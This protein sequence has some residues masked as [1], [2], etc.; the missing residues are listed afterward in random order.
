MPL[1]QLA[2]GARKSA[3]PRRKRELIKE[4]GQRRGAANAS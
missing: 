3:K 2:L 4:A 1:D